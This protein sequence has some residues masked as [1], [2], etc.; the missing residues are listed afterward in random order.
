MLETRFMYPFAIM[1]KQGVALSKTTLFLNLYTA[2]K[3][4]SLHSN[5]TSD[6]SFKRSQFHNTIDS[7]Y[8]EFQGTLWN[9]L[10]YPY[11]DI[12]ELQNWG[13]NKSNNYI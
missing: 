3:T 5:F 1:N 11:L 10:R 12:S 8:L 9:A 4:K 13:K 2:S 6:H 7:R